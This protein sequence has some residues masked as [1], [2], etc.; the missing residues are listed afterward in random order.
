MSSL[1]NSRPC[2]DVCT[3]GFSGIAPAEEAVAEI[4]LLRSQHQYRYGNGNVT[5]AV[6]G[7]LT[8]HEIRVPVSQRSGLPEREFCAQGLALPAMDHGLYKGRG[9]GRLSRRA[10]VRSSTTC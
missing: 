10:L 1:L 5:P 8:W 2:C 7:L 4:C 9:L 3:M 6:S